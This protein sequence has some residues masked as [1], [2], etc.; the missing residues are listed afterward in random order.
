[1]KKLDGTTVV[2]VSTPS[3]R[4]QKIE[5]QPNTPLI[6]VCDI[7]IVKYIQRYT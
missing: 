4:R 1:M 7:A 2:I 5:V 6:K 3:G